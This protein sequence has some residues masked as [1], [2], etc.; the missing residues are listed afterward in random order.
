MTY[1]VSGGVLNSTHA[2]KE[3]LSFGL[4]LLVIFFAFT[5][6]VYLMYNDLTAYSTLG[7]AIVSQVR[8][9]HN[10]FITVVVFIIVFTPHGIHGIN[11]RPIYT[12]HIAGGG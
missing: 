7:A 6:A 11:I 8:N 2:R 12:R 3:I 1:I 4:I 10:V 5:S 9:S